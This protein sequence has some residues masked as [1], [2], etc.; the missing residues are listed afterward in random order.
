MLR[1]QKLKQPKVSSGKR[2]GPGER[3]KIKGVTI[4]NSNNYDLWADTY[5]R[6]D[7]KKGK[8]E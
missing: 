4:I 6:K 2:I 5:K 7:T 8:S 3:L 1:I